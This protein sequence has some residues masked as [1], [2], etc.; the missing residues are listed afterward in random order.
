MGQS[1]A[2]LDLALNALKI[3]KML[4]NADILCD[5]GEVYESLGQLNEARSTY[6]GIL[7]SESHKACE[8]A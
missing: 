5:L 6:G 2:A 3:K 1:K 8:R 4:A 7:N